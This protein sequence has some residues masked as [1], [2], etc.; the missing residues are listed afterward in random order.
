[1]NPAAERQPAVGLKGSRGVAWGLADLGMLGP[2]EREFGE[3]RAG[4]GGRG[5]RNAVG[6]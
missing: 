4:G 6:S 2:G 3:S 1:M 5:K